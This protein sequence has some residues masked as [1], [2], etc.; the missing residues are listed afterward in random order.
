[1]TRITGPSSTS[2]QAS[3]PASNEAVASTTTNTQNVQSSD[4]HSQLA[5]YLRSDGDVVKAYGA[6]DLDGSNKLN[7][8]VE[9]DAQGL[10]RAHTELEHFTEGGGRL[11]AK[12]GTS[13]ISDETRGGAVMAKLQYDT[14]KMDLVGPLT[15]S[16]STK[17]GAFYIPRTFTRRHDIDESMTLLGVGGKY[18][19]QLDTALG[20]NDDVK[21]TG[22]YGISGGMF[23]E[24][25][26]SD[27][28]QEIFTKGSNFGYFDIG[29]FTGFSELTTSANT[30]AEYQIGD[31][32][33]IGLTHN[34]EFEMDDPSIGRTIND[35]SVTADVEVLSLFG[36]NQLD[37]SASVRVPLED[38]TARVGEPGD[39]VVSRL[40]LAYHPSSKLDVNAYAQMRDDQFDGAGVAAKY[41]IDKRWSVGANY[42]YNNNTGEHRASVG[43]SFNF[44]TDNKP[45]RTPEDLMRSNRARN[46]QTPPDSHRVYASEVSGFPDVKN[47]TY[48]EA[49]NAIDTPEKA[50]ALLSPGTLFEYG[51]HELGKMSPQYSFNNPTGT[52]CAEQ[53]AVQAQALR[54]NG[55]D[56]HN[57][58]FFGGG[59]A[60]VITAYKDKE[61]GKWNLMDYN[62]IYETQATN[63]KEAMDQYE[64]GNYEYKLID[65]SDT[66]DKFE[67]PSVS[68]VERAT[69]VREVSQFWNDQ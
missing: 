49:M 38:R 14:G 41:K 66:P 37:A 13:L 68:G 2:T 26:P 45:R 32:A 6:Y 64:P 56:V 69:V 10:R 58:Q 12:L 61:T 5:A 28:T 22:R 3:T 1:M 20:P 44:Y 25:N 54:R 63:I 67:R 53:H 23:V 11:S 60:H 50:A 43:L 52:V 18:E 47:M 34:L 39:G 29:K 46:L 9:G 27:R 24:P 42:D 17:A 57:V 7:A 19:L 51:F 15:H 4:D 55:Y 30:R 8:Y 65:Y 40:D 21:L 59:V 36:R 33:K 16:L 35:H 48:D 62:S 31:R